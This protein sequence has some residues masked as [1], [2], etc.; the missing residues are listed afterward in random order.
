MTW[1]IAG[2]ACDFVGALMLVWPVVRPWGRRH[3][4]TS[5]YVRSWKTQL[6]AG[7]LL[8]GFVFQGYGTYLGGGGR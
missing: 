2:L 6:G 7:L 1:S 4:D 8:L 3:F 5:E